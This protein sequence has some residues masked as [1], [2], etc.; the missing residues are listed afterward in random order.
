[1]NV[2]INASPRHHPVLPV[3]ADRFSPVSRWSIGA[4]GLLL[5][6]VAGLTLSRWL[7]DPA[8]FPVTNVDIMGTLDYADREALQGQIARIAGQGFYAL[9]IDGL[10]SEV[11]SFPW[12]AGARISRVWPGRVSVEVE[13]HEPAALWNQHELI[14]K[15]EVL[16]EPPQLKRDSAR[17]LEWQ[18]VFDALPRLSGATGR[19]SAV[20]EAYREYSLDL[21]R[22]GVSLKSLAED[23]RRSQ[24]L[25]LSND[26]VVK[27]GYEERRF[28]LDR[29]L[30]VF[31]RL[32]TPLDGRRAEFDMRY[33]NGFA[34]RGGPEE[35]TVSTGKV[36]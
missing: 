4:C 6:L 12:V 24:T 31:E 8:R 17:F 13:E 30:D 16:L 22:F 33:S 28:R 7:D 36:Q 1:M 21:E 3:K 19:E 35:M 23:E 20:L 14:A 32:V 15:S 25:T 29:F 5:T 27:L 9:D 2:T 18:R 34:L 26:V 11:E 10:H